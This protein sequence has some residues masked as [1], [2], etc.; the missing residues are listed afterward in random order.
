MHLWT[1]QSTDSVAK[2]FRDG[3]L[4]AVPLR[5]LDTFAS[6]MFAYQWMHRQVA[7]RV[8]E[9]TIVPSVWLWPAR[10]TGHRAPT[11]RQAL[12][13]GRDGGQAL[14]RV[15]IP[16]E[17]VVLSQFRMWEYVLLGQP[18]ARSMREQT[19]WDRRAEDES[20]YGPKLLRPRSVIVE[21]WD[22]IFDLRAGSAKLWGNP[23]RR[24]VQACVQRMELADVRSV[25]V[26][27]LPR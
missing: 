16:T 18:I 27:H 8:G 6:K 25:R 26:V 15:S 9:R 22:R 2:L 14:L 12:G 4:H 11:V 21:T 10:S 19:V 13:D 23:D 20:L 17:R 3:I 24:I 5:A 7:A 1:I